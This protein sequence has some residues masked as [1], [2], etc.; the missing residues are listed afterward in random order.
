MGKTSRADKPTIEQVK[1]KHERELLKIEG[2]QGVGI[3]LDNDKDR[4]VIKIYADKKTKALQER[5]PTELEG[6]PV[7][8]EVSG[9]FHSF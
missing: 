5:V 8:I 4:Q 2:V 1:S 3:G 9:E 7:Q 6:Y